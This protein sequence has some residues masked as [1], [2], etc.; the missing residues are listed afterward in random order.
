M[1]S[2][3]DFFGFGS[4]RRT[5]LEGFDRALSQLQVNPSAIDDGIRYAIYGTVQALAPED[6]DRSLRHAAEL[7]SFC[8]LGP[9]ETAAVW[10]AEARM[11]QEARLTA[12]VEGGG[13]SLDAKVIKLVLLKGIASPEVAARV[14][15]D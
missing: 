10:G 3:W 15:L 13:D 5:A 11:A 1:P 4:K 6:I 8:V 12:A 9:T 7:I 2:F 14:A